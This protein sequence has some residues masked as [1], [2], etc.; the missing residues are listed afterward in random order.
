MLFLYDF[1]YFYVENYGG[2]N[3]KKESEL[4]S[5]I[6]TIGIEPMTSRI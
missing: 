2:V 5:L 1:K 4:D 3:K 6:A